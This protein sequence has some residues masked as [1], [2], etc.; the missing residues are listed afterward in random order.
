MSSGETFEFITEE[1]H[2][3]FQYENELENELENEQANSYEDGTQDLG[4]NNHENS[5]RI[6]SLSKPEH[7]TQIESSLVEGEIIQEEI[8]RTDGEQRRSE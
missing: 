6:P 7:E 5:E 8:I 4:E 2:K 1:E 3:H